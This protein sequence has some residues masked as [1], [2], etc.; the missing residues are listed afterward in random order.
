MTCHTHTR[1]SRFAFLPSPCAQAS[2][3]TVLVYFGVSYCVFHA[4]LCFFLVKEKWVAMFVRKI[5]EVK[6][7]I[8]R[9][10]EHTRIEK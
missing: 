1:L 9:N 4:L 2:S 7:Q 5:G 6:I 10:V 3:V 8:G